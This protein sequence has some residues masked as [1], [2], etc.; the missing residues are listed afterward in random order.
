MVIFGAESRFPAVSGVNPDPVEGIPQI[1][2]EKYLI[3]LN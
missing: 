1:D 3:W 2:F